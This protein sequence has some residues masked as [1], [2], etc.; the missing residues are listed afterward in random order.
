MSI[1]RPQEAASWAEY[2]AAYHTRMAVKFPTLPAWLH[3]RPAL[4]YG[5]RAIDLIRDHKIQCCRLPDAPPKG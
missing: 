3:R 2:W 5:W 4:D 1:F